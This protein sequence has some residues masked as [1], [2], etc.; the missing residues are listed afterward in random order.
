M[1]TVSE[2]FIYVCGVCRLKKRHKIVCHIQSHSQYSA[3]ETDSMSMRLLFCCYNFASLRPP[4][5]HSQSVMLLLLIRF[6][7]LSVHRFFVVVIPGIVL[8]I[9]YLL[10]DCACCCAP[11]SLYIHINFEKVK[12]THEPT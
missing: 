5:T 10:F 2:P 12:E 7:T 6:L 1:D 8:N 11:K 3:T 4:D 9:L